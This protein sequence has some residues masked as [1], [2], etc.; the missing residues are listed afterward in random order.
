MKN[1]S[2][3]VHTSGIPYPQKLKK[4]KLEKQFV[5]F[6]D[7]FKKLH[8]NMPF[9]DALE[10]MP[11]YIKF[12]KKI[13][14]NEKKFGEYGTI[15]LTEECS[16]ILLKK[17]P[18]KLQDPG[19]FSIPNSLSCKALSDLGA[20]INLMSL[21]MFKRSNSRE[22]KPIAIMLQMADRS[23]KHPQDVIEKF[24]LK[25]DK[26]LFSADFVI[27]DMEEDDK[28]LIILSRPFLATGKA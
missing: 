26:F 27:L 28:A 5:K 3:Q 22:A 8:I 1:H 19:S 14:V 12:M 11:S 16:V 10:N 18:P 17:L 13:L 24:L 2:V 7:I 25:V 4:G 20:I 6:L 9:M 23:Y 21:L 15:S